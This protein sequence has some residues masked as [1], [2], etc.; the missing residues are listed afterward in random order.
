MAI[1]YSPTLRCC[2]PALHRTSPSRSVLTPSVFFRTPTLRLVSVRSQAS[3]SDAV[4]S[5]KKHSHAAVGLSSSS[6]VIDFLTLC[7]RLKVPYN[8]HK[9]TKVWNLWYFSLKFSCEIC[10][11]LVLSSVVCVILEFRIYPLLWKR[12]KKDLVVVILYHIWCHFFML[13]RLGRFVGVTFHFCF[14]LMLLYMAKRTLSNDPLYWKWWKHQSVFF[15]FWLRKR[16]LLWMKV[17]AFSIGSTIAWEGC[18]GNWLLFFC[19]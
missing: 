12:I 6:S 15:I 8:C 1:H 19:W 5:A 11:P 10:D 3:G 16:M 4:G 9:S 18:S 14:L 7:H 13:R 17:D 2:L